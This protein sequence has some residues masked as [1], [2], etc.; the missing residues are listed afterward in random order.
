MQ[1]GT[2]RPSCERM[3]LGSF[4][5]AVR[6]SSL[7]AS[8]SASSLTR[9]ANGEDRKRARRRLSTHQAEVQTRLG[10]RIFAQVRDRW[11][12]ITLSCDANSAYRMK[13]LDAIADWDQFNLLMIEQPLWYDDF[14]FHSMLQ[15][16]LDTPSVSTNPFATAATLSPLSTWSPAAS[17]TSRSAALAASPRPSPST[18]QLTSAAF[19]SGAVECS[20]PASAAPTTSRCRPSQFLVSGRR[21]CLQP[22][23]EGGHHR[24]GGHRQ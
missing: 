6:T 7:V 11:P 4:S 14:Y 9:A 23:L 5:A 10:H 16:R 22:L 17:S 13:D 12:D 3:S 24:A 8:R 18:T 21:L 1:S 20:S 2:L 19:R 15:K